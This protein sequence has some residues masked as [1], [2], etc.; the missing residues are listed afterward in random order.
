V[1][2]AG[3]E[4]DKHSALARHPLRSGRYYRP[5]F[6]KSRWSI[7]ALGAF[8]VAGALALS[9]CGSSSTTVP[10]S[11]VATVAGNPI[12]TR[13]FDHWMYVDAKGEAEQESGE[14]VIIP[15]PQDNYKGCIATVRADIP[16]LAK[17]KTATI[18][19]D[20]KQLFTSYSSQVMDFLIK[21][22]WY[23]A[24]AHKQG[25]DLTDAQVATALAKAKKSEFK[26][27][28]AYTAFLSESG[29]TTA[30]I[31]YRV[32]VNQVFEKLV[33]KHKKAVTNA[34]VTAYYNAHKSTYGTPERRNLKIVLA[35]TPATAAAAEKALKSGKSWTVV[36]KQYSTD[37]TTKDKGGVLTDVTKGQEEAAL[38][39]AAFSAP[40]NK[41]EGPIKTTF[42]Y[43]LVEVTKIIPATQ[44]SLADV[45]STVK[46]TLTS[47]ASSAAQKTV[48][49]AAEK[50]FKPRTFC[51]K[52]YAMADCSNY[53]A[54]K[55]TSTS[56]TTGATGST[57]AAGSTAT[58][59]TATAPASTTS[60]SSSST[61]KS[62]SS[63]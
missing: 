32:R 9:A 38:S 57:G 61:T 53:V 1:P 48:E 33:N 63:Q 2:A 24:E 46:S 35:K 56:A 22:Y 47:Q 60:A 27:A 7:P 10:S 41:L 34:D 43:Y 8:F 21:A 42:G 6:M 49:A 31:T 30:D 15:D 58:A 25:V 18:L 20:C 52:T 39:D 23:Q 4:A 19:S 50:S 54:P 29:Q 3:E 40:V 12:S 36:A 13:A 14:P 44:K 11:A 59:T 26:T 37:P 62:K 51:K 55:T 16:S 17:T 28:S 5:R 45:Q